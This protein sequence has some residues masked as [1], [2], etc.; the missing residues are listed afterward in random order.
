MKKKGNN[1]CDSQ[2]TIYVDPDEKNMQQDKSESNE[3]NQSQNLK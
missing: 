2:G 3:Q 1:D